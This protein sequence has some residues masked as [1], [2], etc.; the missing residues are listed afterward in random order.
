MDYRTG[1]LGVPNKEVNWISQ[2]MRADT[3]S[4]LIVMTPLQAWSLASLSIPRNLSPLCVA[5]PTAQEISK[6]GVL[7]LTCKQTEPRCP[8]QV[9][10]Q[11]KRGK[12]AGGRRRT[13]CDS[14][15]GL[16]VDFYLCILTRKETD[17][18]NGHAGA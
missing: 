8:R 1:W 17:E 16:E 5:G 9:K 10:R 6:K 13:G 12:G 7:S 15:K 4:R 11:K 2:R 14:E 3:W 18:L